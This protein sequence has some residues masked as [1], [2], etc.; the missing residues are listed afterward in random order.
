MSAEQ[1]PEEGQAWFEYNSGYLG[2]YT[3]KVVISG[4][5][6][7]ASTGKAPAIQKNDAITSPRIRISL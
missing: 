7:V 5:G 6:S 2:E 4:T 3:D 1:K